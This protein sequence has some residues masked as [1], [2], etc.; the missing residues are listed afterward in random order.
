MSMNKKMMQEIMKTATMAALVAVALPDLA[1]AAD[2]FG[3][4]TSSILSSQ[5]INVPRLVQALCYI[6][7]LMMMV[8]G[9]LKLRAHAENPTGT[10]IQHGIGR[11]LIGGSI[12]ALPSL[13]SWVTKSTQITGSGNTYTTLTP[14]F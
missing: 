6:G 14:T 11:L 10:P 4:T 8:S 1:I 13:S 5:L 2:D 3:S 9:A 12:A 7:G